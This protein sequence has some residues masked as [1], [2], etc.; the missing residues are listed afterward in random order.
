MST[1]STA[2]QNTPPPNHII[3]IEANIIANEKEK[4]IKI[5]NFWRHRILS[6]CRDANVK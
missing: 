3:I 1:L 6:T 5:D 4:S 2:K